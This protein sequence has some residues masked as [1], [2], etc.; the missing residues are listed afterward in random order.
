MLGSFSCFDD[1]ESRLREVFM[2]TDNIVNG[3]YFANIVKEV[4]VPQYI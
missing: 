1:G 4:K 2:K 3:K